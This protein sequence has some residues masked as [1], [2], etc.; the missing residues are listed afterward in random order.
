[1]I[2]VAEIKKK[3][4]LG[5]FLSILYP[6]D[7]GNNTEMKPLELLLRRSDKKKRKGPKSRNFGIEIL[8]KDSGAL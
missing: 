3:I 1:M 5:V 8:S 2:I 7:K 4:F 6:H